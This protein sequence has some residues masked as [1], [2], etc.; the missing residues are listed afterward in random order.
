MG[1][2]GLHF[3]IAIA[4]QVTIPSTKSAARWDGDRVPAELAGRGRHFIEGTA[5]DE[6]G[7][8]LLVRT[9]RDGG[10][11]RLGQVRRFVARAR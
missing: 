4:A 1:D 11:M 7:G 6:P 10:R 8:N 5:A 9:V 2:A 3:R